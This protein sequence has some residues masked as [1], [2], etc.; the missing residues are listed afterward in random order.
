MF[1]LDFLSFS[2]ILNPPFREDP[3]RFY[4]SGWNIYCSFSLLA[5]RK[6]TIRLRRGFGGTRKKGR[7]VKPSTRGR[8]GLPGKDS[9]VFD[10]F[11]QPQAKVEVYGKQAGHSVLRTTLCFWKGPALEETR[12]VQTVH[13]RNPDLSAMLDLVTTGL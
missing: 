10:S 11:P 7:P 8:G 5:Q 12:F 2:F 13:E 6:R 3:E 4:R 9:V 1:C